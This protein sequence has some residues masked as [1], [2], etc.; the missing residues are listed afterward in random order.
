MNGEGIYFKRYTIK[1]PLFVELESIPMQ[2]RGAII[3]G[4]FIFFHLISM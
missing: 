1:I 3:H 2:N 4:V